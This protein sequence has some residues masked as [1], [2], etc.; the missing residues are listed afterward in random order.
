[1]DYLTA[2]ANFK[3]ASAQEQEDQQT[4]L[5]FIKN[6]PE[7]VLLRENKIAH[8]T[9]SALILNESMDK[10]LMIY[11]NIYQSWSWT[12][13]HADGDKDLLKVA[14]KEAGEETG[15]V[16][17]KAVS[18]KIVSLDILPVFGHIKNDQP[19]S[20]HLHLSVAYL[21]QA[22]ESEPVSIK[23][24]ENSGVKW[25]PIGELPAYV[26][27]PHMQVVYDKILLRLNTNKLNQ[28]NNKGGSTHVN[29][30]S[31]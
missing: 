15:L 27:E 7:N 13:G 3:P 11:H 22:S 23:P 29:S 26:S 28:L 1:M 16:R 25:I 8:L 14:I 30:Q 2:I 17:I 12:G 19:V 9:G 4:M 24:D 6:Y 10:L 31:H 21:L 20:A 18:D 5:A